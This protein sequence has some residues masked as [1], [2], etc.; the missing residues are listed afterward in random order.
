M[1]GVWIRTRKTSPTG[2]NKGKPRHSVWFRTAGRGAPVL[3]AGTFET[4]REAGKP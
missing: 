2:R 4:L 3:Y 1:S